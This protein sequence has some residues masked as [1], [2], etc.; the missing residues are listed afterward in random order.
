M[1][2]LAIASSFLPLYAKLD[3]PIRKK[4]DEA[5][6]KFT[7]H[8]HAG[9]HL[10]KLTHAKDPRIR[11]IRIDNYWRGVVLAPDQGDVYCLL[12]VLGE[13]KANS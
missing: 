1:A 10:E 12:A 7:E 8:T 4:V 11:T 6:A 3:P 13:E 9:L 2:Q 5:I